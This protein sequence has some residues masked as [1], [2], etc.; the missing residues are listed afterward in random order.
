MKKD[1]NIIIIIL[2]ILII[3]LGVI[4][5]L[6]VLQKDN[7]NISENETQKN[8]GSSLSDEEI[9]ESMNELKQT[10]ENKTEKIV[11]I[12]NGEKISEREISY[13]DYQLNNNYV[14][15]SG[16]KK[17]AIAEAI[18]QY[19]ILTKAKEDNITL[20]EAREKQIE[21]RIK[22]N[23]KEGSEETNH[24]LEAFSMEY[25]EF[26]KFYIDR[27]KKSEIIS[28]WKINIAD[29]IN[30]GEINLD[31][32]NFNSKYNEY[33]SSTD[34]SKR[35]KLLTELKE[36]YLDYLKSQATIEYIN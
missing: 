4:L 25:D 7:S 35:Y 14:N 34:T 32:K 21:E 24:F 6:K 15:Q 30:N 29:E 5:A 19:V 26:M 33:K 36:I 8:V 20:T 3:T 1:K 11:L 22:K 27:N 16:E 12:V 31:D 18:E 2:I 10:L 28:Q 17:D 13:I 9:A 23:L